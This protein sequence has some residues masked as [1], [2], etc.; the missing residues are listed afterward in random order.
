M[1][2]PPPASTATTTATGT[3]E[4]TDSPTSTKST[5]SSPKPKRRLVGPYPRKNKQPP[6]RQDAAVQPTKSISV[7]SS[8]P[9]SNNANNENENKS[10]S[11][12]SSFRMPPQDSSSS[13]S[14]AV[15]PVIRKLSSTRAS[16]ASIPMSPSSS[17]SKAKA[18][19]NLALKSSPTISSAKTPSSTA[20]RSGSFS[21]HMT[22]NKNSAHGRRASI[23][24]HVRS[25]TA[26]NGNSGIDSTFTSKSHHNGSSMATKS[27]TT[28]S[29]SS[30]HR[31]SFRSEGNIKLP[32]PATLSQ[33]SRSEDISASLIDASSPSS[34]PVTRGS[35]EFQRV[36]SVSIEG[37][38]DRH[39]A[40]SPED[41]KKIVTEETQNELLKNQQPT[42][43]LS[44]S[45]TTTATT[46]TTTQPKRYQK[47]S[48]TPPKRELPLKLSR[49][50]SVDSSSTCSTTAS[51]QLLS[52][53]SRKMAKPSLIKAKLEEEKRKRRLIRQRED[54]AQARMQK[55]K[56]EIQQ[57][58]EREKKEQAE[59]ELKELQQVS[60]LAA[61]A[62]EEEDSDVYSTDDDDALIGIIRPKSPKS[63]KDA[64]MVRQNSRKVISQMNT[65]FAML[66]FDDIDDDDQEEAD[67]IDYDDLVHTIV[68]Q[69]SGSSPASNHKSS[70]NDNEHLDELLPLSNHSIHEEVDVTGDADDETD[71]NNITLSPTKN[72]RNNRRRPRV[73]R[74]SKPKRNPSNLVPEMRRRISRKDIMFDDD[75]IMD[76]ISSDTEDDMDEIEG[77]RMT[78]NKRSRSTHGP[79][80]RS[81]SSGGGSGMKSSSS[82]SP[83]DRSSKSARSKRSSMTE[84]PSSESSPSKSKSSSATNDQ[85]ARSRNNN[86]ST[87][88]APGPARNNRAGA[89]RFK[90][91]AKT[92]D[93][94]SDNEK[95]AERR[96]K[97]DQ[98]KIDFQRG[99]DLCWKFQ[100]SASALMEFRK[101]LFVRES[102]LGKFH[103]DT[104]RTYYW[105]GRS[106]L[107]LKE[108]EE[109]LVAFSRALRIFERV[110][111]KTHK[112]VK[113]TRSAI[114]TV[115]REMDQEKEVLEEYKRAVEDSIEY[116]R[117]GDNYR[118]KGKL[119]EAIEE[120][121]NAIDNIEEYHPDAADLYVKIAIIFRRQGEFERALDEYR[122]AS[123]IYELSL[124]AD[125]PE[126]VKTLNNL[127][128][129]RRLGQVSMALMQQL[130]NAGIQ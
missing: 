13:S 63:T 86:D 58:E 49:S 60:E 92:D 74:T 52:P 91:K 24:S 35:N 108:F 65:S 4:T 29:S 33:R 107:K 50:N 44:S 103:E 37:F 31:R 120:Y 96:E 66:S 28:T 23:S 79:S 1:N 3:P 15:R 7:D 93:G 80:R 21:N 6:Q 59:K 51:Q 110:L 71:A 16:I 48:Q 99:H 94:K 125:H 78:E 20:I 45:S 101:A 102:N 73:A 38:H 97:L 129:K 130:N 83:K 123:E 112:Y 75:D 126:T 68:E 64:R 88:S 43:Q 84:L 39:A 77:N 34:P 69:A 2:R 109:G 127:I 67:E 30:N 40:L 42:Q 121:R 55:I 119:S 114:D 54:Q 56:A 111:M 81:A 47:V 117:V 106:L 36:R 95:M 90:T 32:K 18:K 113:W 9:Q 57:I 25:P 116:E 27:A 53:I 10:S 61:L 105:I 87:H 76:K 19:L 17:I 26:S 72:L 41:T 124:G 8:N 104:G 128:E 89:R 14:T 5:N 62:Y 122:F 115:F 46:T 12:R 100:D 118:K 82:S 85:D 11:S 98:A 22:Y 70:S